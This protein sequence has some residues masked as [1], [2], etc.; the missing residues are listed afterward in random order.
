[1]P[2]DVAIIITAIVVAFLI[3]G[4]TLAWAEIQTRSPKK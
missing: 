4:A 2:T 1:M 3:F